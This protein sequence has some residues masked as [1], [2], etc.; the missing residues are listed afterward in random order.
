MLIGIFG[1]KRRND[2]DT[3]MSNRRSSAEILHPRFPE[4]ETEAEAEAG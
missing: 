1:S 2:I 4:A 3:N